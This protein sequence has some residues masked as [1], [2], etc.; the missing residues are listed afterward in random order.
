MVDFISTL[1]NTVWDLMMIK[2][3]G[4][5]F[6]II[7]AFLGAAFAVIALRLVL[8]MFDISL[9]TSISGA[10]A[11][12]NNRKIKIANARKDDVK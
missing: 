5:D 1:F 3:P 7:Y 4:F 11:S 6:P 9:S 10:V 12:G 8:S 2:W